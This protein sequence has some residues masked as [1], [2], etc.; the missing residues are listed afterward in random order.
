MASTSLYAY[1]WDLM[2][3]AGDRAIA[4]ARAHGIGG[5]TL[6]TAYHAGKFIRP[7]TEESKVVFPEDSTIY[8]RPH[9]N[10]GRVKPQV[11]RVTQQEDV[12]AKLTAR[13]DLAVYGWTV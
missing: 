8:F 2:G 11:S 13:G 10:Y 4:E 1:A 12:L 3:A 7:W 6:A 5:I 9:G